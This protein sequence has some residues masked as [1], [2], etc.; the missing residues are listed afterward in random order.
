[1]HV[2]WEYGG[3]EVE[4][5]PAVGYKLYEDNFIWS[6]VSFQLQTPVRLGLPT[7]GDMV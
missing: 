4:A 5:M 2:L 3:A 7:G 6:R 1:M